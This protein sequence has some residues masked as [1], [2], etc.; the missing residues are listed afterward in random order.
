VIIDQQNT[1]FRHQTFF[2]FRHSLYIERVRLAKTASLSSR[3]L[4]G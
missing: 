4:I 2:P 1:Y 3:S